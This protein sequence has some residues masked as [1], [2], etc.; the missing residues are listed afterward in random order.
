MWER[1]LLR[2]VLGLWLL[3]TALSFRCW[4]FLA[5]YFHLIDFGLHLLSCPR[6]F[7]TQNAIMGHGG[8]DQQRVNIK[9]ED[10]GPGELPGYETMPICLLW[11]LSC[12]LQEIV[13][14]ADSNLIW[15]ELTNVK[16]H[17][18]FVVVEVDL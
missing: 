7:Y 9:R 10:I 16:E 8:F 11:V 5:C 3:L 13:H 15:R 6:S 4:L 14:C 1:T 2:D 12:H 18:E 17:L